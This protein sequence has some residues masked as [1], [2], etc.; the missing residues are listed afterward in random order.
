MLKKAINCV[1]KNLL[2]LYQKSADLEAINNKVLKH[3]PESI[4][5]HI[6]IASYDKG[7][8]VLSY[9]SAAI[10]NEL[11]YLL[12]ELRSNLRSQEQMYTLV[13]IKTLFKK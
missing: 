2:S 3:I 13:N 11:R 5:P 6:S 4:R 9:R 10:A 7:I 8:L 12:P 1:N